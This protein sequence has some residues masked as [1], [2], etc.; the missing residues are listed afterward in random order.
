MNRVVGVVSDLGLG[1]LLDDAEHR[2]DEERQQ[3]TRKRRQNRDPSMVP[4][5]SDLHRYLLWLVSARP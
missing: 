5:V 1:A 3:R 2:G 4:G